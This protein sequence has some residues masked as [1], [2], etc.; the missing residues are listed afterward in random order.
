MKKRIELDPISRETFTV[1][2]LLEALSGLPGDMPVVAMLD[3][4]SRSCME[5][6]A[7]EIADSIVGIEVQDA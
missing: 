2:D 1:S 3:N 7:I 4:P 5:I 6:T